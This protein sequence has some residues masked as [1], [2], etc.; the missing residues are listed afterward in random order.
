MSIR[1][2]LVA[3]AIPAVVG[4]GVLAASAPAHAAV[5]NRTVAGHCTGTSRST[6]QVSREDT[7][8]LSVDFGV[9]MARH[10]SGVAWRV[11]EADNG[12][13]FYH[14]TRYTLGDGSFDVSRLISPQPGTNTITA[15]ATNPATGETCT[16]TASL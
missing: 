5:N 12:T 4:L 13:T 1:T 9:D 11:S 16:A 8:K 14:G 6:L 2:R 10:R 3:I 15:S 7:G